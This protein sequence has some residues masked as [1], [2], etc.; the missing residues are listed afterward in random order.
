NA[1]RQAADAAFQKLTLEYVAESDRYNYGHQWTWL[2]VPIIQMPADIM[3]V[4]EII[5]RTK[6][7]IIIETGIAWGGSV[8]FYASLLDLIG[9]GRVIAIDQVLPDN[10]IEAITNYR[11]AE[12]ISLISGSST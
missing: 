7:T 9:K 3:A 5:W 1:G 6:P 11:F 8:V 10:N 12:R 2:G 4:Q